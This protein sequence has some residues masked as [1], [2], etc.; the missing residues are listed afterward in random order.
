VPDA[1]NFKERQDK[2]FANAFIQTLKGKAEGALTTY[3]FY[4]LPKRSRIGKTL[5]YNIKEILSGAKAWDRYTQ[6]TTLLSGHDFRKDDN[7]IIAYAIKRGLS[8]LIPKDITLISYGGG[9]EKAFIENEGQIINTLLNSSAHEIHGFQS[10]DILARYAL[11]GAITAS[12]DYRLIS[13][14]IRGDFLNNGELAL[15]RSEGSPVVMIFGGSFENTPVDKRHPDAEINASIAWAKMNLQHGLGS[16]VIKTFDAN[17]KPKS[18]LNKYKPTKHFEAFILSGFARAMQQGVIKDKNYDIFEY[19]RMQTRYNTDTNSIQLISACKKSHVLKT[20]HGDIPFRGESDPEADS[21][22]ITLSHK[23][24][25]ATHAHIAERAGWEITEA[26]SQPRNPNT[27]IIATAVRP[28]DPKIL[29]LI[30]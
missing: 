7:N 12:Q 13:N 22:V 5:N 2:A 15:A 29:R 8:K 21:R 17:Q 18:Q 26:Y 20:S 28:P 23:W 9:G 4:D 11:S 3:L 27:L 10:V 25:L 6:E 24:N 16:T 30:R 19:W 14:G 1:E